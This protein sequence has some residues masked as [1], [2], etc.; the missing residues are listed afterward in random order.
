MKEGKRFDGRK[1]EEHR[2]IEVEYDI[3]KNA[4]S[5]VSVKFGKT[6]VLVGVKLGVTTPYPDSPDA[7]TFMTSAELR[8]LASGEFEFGPPKINSIELA[9]VI[10]RGIRE[11]G[12]IDFKKLCIKEGEKVWQVFVDIIAIN[13]DGNLM[14]VAGLG[15]LIALGRAKMP[16]YDAEN[17]K[18]EHELSKDDLPLDREA[19]AF[20]MTLHKIGDKI[21]A[22]PTVEEEKASD[23]RLTIAVADNKGEPSI[24]AMQKGKE[25]AISDSD[26][27]SIL[28]LVE[29]KFKEMFP[30]V[31]E[32]VFGK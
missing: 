10:D 28:K 6:H 21:V 17:D 31:K 25:G 29:V 27:D 30:T 14:D 24:T 26:M 12:F 32:Y 4:E 7:G 23:Y 5:S 15:A 1:P 13:D 8:P 2:K 9:R 11:S 22:D 16:V 3:S 19:L 18:L 20:S